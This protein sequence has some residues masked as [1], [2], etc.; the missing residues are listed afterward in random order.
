MYMEAQKAKAE[1]G[2]EKKKKNTCERKKERKKESDVMVLSYTSTVPRHTPFPF[3][4]P[5]S[6]RVKT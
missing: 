1:M 2:S 5:R 6:S 3:S 4:G